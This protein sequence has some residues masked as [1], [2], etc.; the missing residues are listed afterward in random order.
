MAG[1]T[2]LRS[3]LVI[4]AEDKGQKLV[5]ISTSELAVSLLGTLNLIRARGCVSG[6][7]SSCVGE[8]RIKYD[9]LLIYMQKLLKI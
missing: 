4:L 7:V 9:A 2:R 1:F 6:R 8:T 3:N 5:N